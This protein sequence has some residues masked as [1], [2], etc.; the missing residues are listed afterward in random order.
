MRGQ[1]TNSTWQP[2][3]GQS[4]SAILWSTNKSLAKTNDWEKTLRSLPLDSVDITHIKPPATDRGQR[5]MREGGG[6][7]WININM[8]IAL[9]ISISPPQLAVLTVPVPVVMWIVLSPVSVTV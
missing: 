5:G 1:L 2:A 6:K 4:C 3:V 7:S 9:L 8:Q